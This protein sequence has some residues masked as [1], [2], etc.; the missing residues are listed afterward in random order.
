MRSLVIGLIAAAGLMIAAPAQAANE[1]VYST[2]YINERAAAP[3]RVHKAAV[4]RTHR[5]AMGHRARASY[6]YA[7]G[8]RRG[9]SIANDPIRRALD[10]PR[11]YGRPDRH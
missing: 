5:A 4:K 2:N 11:M 3:K 9:S 1:G 6:A 7:P 10:D 8:Y